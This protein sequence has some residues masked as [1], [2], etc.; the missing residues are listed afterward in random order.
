MEQ[1]DHIMNLIGDQLVGGIDEGLKY[2]LQFRLRGI[3]YT[4]Q[5]EKILKPLLRTIPWE[6]VQPLPESFLFEN[7][8]YWQEYFDLIKGTCI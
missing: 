5:S 4:L 3:F 2:E 1:A 8:S 6:Q 7:C